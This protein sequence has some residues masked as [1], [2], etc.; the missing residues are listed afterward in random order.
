M[1]QFSSVADQT[2]MGTRHDT[3]RESFG[4]LV[5]ALRERTGQS[6]AVLIDEYDNDK[7]IRLR[8]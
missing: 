3:S 8:R 6:V 7:P 1:A 4:H 5:R 2:G